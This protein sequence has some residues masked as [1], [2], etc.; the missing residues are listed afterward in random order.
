[1]DDTRTHE[2]PPQHCRDLHDHERPGNALGPGPALGVVEAPAT[3]SP[4]Q[5]S[6]GHP[7]AAVHPRYRARAQRAPRSVRQ[8]VTMGNF[9][10]KSTVTLISWISAF[11]LPWLRTSPCRTASSRFTSFS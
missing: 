1:S 11:S 6:R 2:T 7:V 9:G 8:G 4:P 5:G 3:P 10:S